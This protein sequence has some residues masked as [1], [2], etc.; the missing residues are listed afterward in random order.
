MG[1]VVKVAERPARPVMIYDG[2]CRFCYFWI[3]RWKL[4]TGDRVEYV[5]SQEVMEQGRFPEIPESEYDRSVQFVQTDGAVQS[6]AEGVAESL[7]TRCGLIAKVF[8]GVPCLAP[9]AEWGYAMVA[10]RRMLFSRISSFFFGGNPGLPEY[11][12]TMWLFLRGLGLIYLIAFTSLVSQIMPLSGSEGLVPIAAV[13]ERVENSS[14]SPWQ[15]PTMFWFGAGDGFIHFVCGLGCV[16]AACVVAG[17]LTMP[18]LIGLWILYLSLT[19]VCTPWLNFQWDILLLEA[20]AIGIFASRMVWFEN[21]RHLPRPPFITILLARWL[22]FRLMFASGMVKLLSEDWFWLN[23]VA[24]TVHYETQPLP[25]PLSWHFHNLPQWFH[26]RSCDLMFFIELVVPFLIFLPRNLRIFASGSTVLLM[27]VIIFSGNYTFFNFLT[28]V[29]C[30]ALLDDRVVS[31]ALPGRW[32]EWFSGEPR[33]RSHERARWWLRVVPTAGLVVVTVWLSVIFMAPMFKLPRP[34]F[35]VGPARGV[36][37]FRIVNSY[38]LFAN[39]THERPE[40]VLEGSHDGETWKAYEFHYK[41]GDPA[42]RPPIIAPHQ[43]RLDWQMWFAALGQVQHN[44]WVLTLAVQLLQDKDSA[45]S[46]FAVNPFPDAPPKYLRA[47][48]YNYNFTTPEERAASGNWWK[49]R[50]KGP[51]FPPIKLPEVTRTRNIDAGND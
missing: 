16:L 27:I 13:M 26:M 40:I 24:L 17:F 32:K 31:W 1:D 23:S 10:K 50:L 51:Y 39:M 20:G 47:V 33:P 43:P 21:P 19:Q 44:Q 34:E 2:E 12:L 22:V 14:A 30:I 8:R 49:R 42:R 15:V 11:R 35:M 36:M 18:S 5:S 3:E 29:L 25:N 38:G 9:V 7:A 6:G 28:I 37:Q 48:V 45:K 46:F 41:P 4:W